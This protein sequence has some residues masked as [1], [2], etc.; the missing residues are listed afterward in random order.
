MV[1][2]LHL[3]VFRINNNVLLDGGTDITIRINDQVICI[4]KGIYGGESRSSKTQYGNL[5]ETL[6]GLTD[7]PSLIKI[8]KGDRL[9]V[10]AN[11]DLGL[12]PA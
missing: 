3:S 2:S 1:I 7:C 9:N 4:S 5:Q 6:S 10:A 8:K 12:H 11:F